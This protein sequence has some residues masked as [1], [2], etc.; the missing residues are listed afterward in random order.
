MLTRGDWLK[1]NREVN[2]GVPSFLHPLPPGADGSRMTFAK[3]LMDSKSPTTARVFRQSHLAVVFRHGISRIAG[4]FRP[5][6]E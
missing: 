2:A 3:W 5:A 4:G 6:R 1:P